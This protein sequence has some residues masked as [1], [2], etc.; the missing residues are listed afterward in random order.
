[1]EL[2]PN[3]LNSRFISLQK[4]F[5]NLVF[6]ITLLAHWH[7]TVRLPLAKLNN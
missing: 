6:D 1:M 5:I 4:R 7:I 2:L 3:N